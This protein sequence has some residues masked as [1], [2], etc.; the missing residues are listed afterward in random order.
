MNCPSCSQFL[1]RECPA[2]GRMVAITVAGRFVAHHRS[3]V[4]GSHVEWGACRGS[5][6]HKSEGKP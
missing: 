2:C 1:H 6:L 3:I 4:L 5:G